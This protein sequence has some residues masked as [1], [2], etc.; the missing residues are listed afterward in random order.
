MQ[1]G[2]VIKQYERF[3]RFE[4][5]STSAELMRGRGVYLIGWTFIISQIF[6]IVSMTMSSGYWTLDHTISIS[7]SLM[8]FCL[9]HCLRFSKNFIVYAIAYSALLL[10]GILVSALDQAT[11][12][13][14][15]LLPLLLAGALMNGFCLLYTSPSPRDKR[16]ARM[17]SSA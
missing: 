1:F 14:S 10:G 8:L 6:N 5:L 15:A 16:Q 9:I 4:E 2:D 12:I 17:P 13:N 3:L 7:A 11:G